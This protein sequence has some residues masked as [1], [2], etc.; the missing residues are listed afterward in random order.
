MKLK[1]FIG[2]DIRGY[3]NFKIDFNDSITFLIGIN[4]TGKTTI[5]KLLSGL[6]YPSY[7]ELAQIEFS[8]I[9]LIIEEKISS[10]LCKISCNKKKDSIILSYDNLSKDKKIESVFNLVE[11]VNIK[12]SIAHNSFEAEKLSRVLFEF[13]NLDVVE[14]I[15]S[16]RTPLFLGLN[17]RVGDN[18]ISSNSFEKEIYF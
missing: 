2:K 13:D 5:L 10:D 11:L 17:R 18:T 6:L 3:L 12:N 15:R 4:G 7:I 8:Y 1:R 16:L 14:K 9:E